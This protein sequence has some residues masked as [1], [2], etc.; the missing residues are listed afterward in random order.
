M[1]NEDMNDELSLFNTDEGLL[2]VRP[3]TS[4]D[5]QLAFIDTYRDTQ[6]RN[7]QEITD[8]T[9]GLGSDVPNYH[10]GLNGVGSYLKRRYQDAPTASRIAN[11]QTAA[12]LS[13]LNTAMSNYQDRL[14]EQYNQAYRSYNNKAAAMANSGSGNNNPI[15]DPLDEALAGG[16]LGGDYTSRDVIEQRAAEAGLSGEVV[17]TTTQGPDGYVYQTVPVGGVE[18]ILWTNNPQYSKGADGF[19][20]YSAMTSGQRNR[21]LL[22]NNWPWLAAGSLLATPVTGPAAAISA[23]AGLLGGSD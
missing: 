23:L 7:N 18:K 2:Q 20:T 6:A 1:Y 11:L 5:E 22:G 19:Y 8:Q 13:A 12:Q 14:N 9:R 10:G 16:V 21:S 4:R 15:T 17:A 3:E